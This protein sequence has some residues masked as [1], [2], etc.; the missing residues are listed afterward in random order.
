[1]DIGVKVFGPDLDTID[2]VSKDIEAALKPVN[3]A[4]DVVAT[5][6]MGKG[7]LR[8]DINTEKA[9]RYGVSVE[10]L[11]NTVEIALGGQAV[12][13]TVQGRERFPV[14]L[15]FPRAQR[16]DEETV[17]RLLVSGTG[18][19]APA[20]T[21]ASSGRSSSMSE[22]A[23]PPP[24]GLSANALPSAARGHSPTGTRPLQIPLGEDRK[25]V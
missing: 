22:G 6:I 16:E 19:P 24:A 25:S 14:R 11:K 3:G 1:T 5:P 20:M 17:R 13:Q 21:G 10:D 15:R 23:S 12:T 9:S 2:R 8:I 7:Y 4:R 18:M